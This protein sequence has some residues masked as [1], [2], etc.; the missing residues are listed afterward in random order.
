[1]LYDSATNSL[2]DITPGKSDNCYIGAFAIFEWNM[3]VC[4]DTSLGYDALVFKNISTNQTQKVSYPSTYNL[5]E[6]DLNGKYLVL[7][8]DGFQ[9]D[10]DRDI[11]LCELKDEWLE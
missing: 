2:E 9:S 1:M 3:I 5:F 6:M 4:H 11:Y 8:G 10:E 7:G